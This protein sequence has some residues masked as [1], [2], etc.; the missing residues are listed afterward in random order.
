MRNLA[1]LLGLETQTLNNQKVPAL[2]L[3][4]KEVAPTDP[5]VMAGVKREPNGSFGIVY[6]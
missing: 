4:A 5:S 6:M 1:R 3:T 2:N